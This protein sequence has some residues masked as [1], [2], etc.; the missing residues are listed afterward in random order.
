VT[1][2]D[3]LDLY[4]ERDAPEFLDAVEE[5]T[6]WE[7][8]D[9]ERKRKEYK[10]KKTEFRRLVKGYTANDSYSDFEDQL[11][12]QKRKVVDGSVDGCVLSP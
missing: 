6:A 12:I 2:D 8:R 5:R 7:K 11:S 3:F 10:D 9:R 4:D 1:L